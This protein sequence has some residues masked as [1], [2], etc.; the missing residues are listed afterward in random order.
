MADLEKDIGELKGILKPLAKTLEKISDRV[1][2]NRDKITT[3]ETALGFHKKEVWHA[4][5]ELEKETKEDRKAAD[6]D[7]KKIA[8]LER[9]VKELTAR[10]RGIGKFLL[11]VAQIM[12]AA[13]VG[14][15]AARMFGG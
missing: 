14:G 15:I 4:V 2:E 10:S 5:R 12:V 13:V 9:D 7:A 3:A 11:K 8:A 6:E 1:N